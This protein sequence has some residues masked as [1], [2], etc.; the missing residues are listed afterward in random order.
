MNDAHIPILLAAVIDGLSPSAGGC[1]I[2][3]T[4]GAGGHAEALLRASGSDGRLL[5]FDRDAAALAIARSRLAGFGTRL[6]TVQDSFEKMDEL[7]PL[8]GFAQVDGI[9][10]DLGLSSMQVDNPERGFS[11]Q[12]DGPLDMR[13]DPTADIPTAAD[14]VNTLPEDNLVRLLRDYGEERYA[15]RIAHAIVG[16]RPLHTTGALAEVVARAVPRK[17]RERIHPA[18]RTFQ[19]LRIAVNDE[20]GALERTLPSAIALLSRGG[21]LAVISFHSLEDR[22]VKT[23]MRRESRDCICP[24]EQPVCT[25]DHRAVTRIITRKPIM[26]TEQEVSE[27]PRARSAKLRVAERL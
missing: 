4:L 12:H 19:A 15:R 11:F 10:L 22:I 17:S 21:R 8:H 24:P 7:A 25:C 16:A 9:L 1:Y 6:V 18:T 27:N 13:F 5:G 26:A 20:L 23:F 14:L 3:G 2:D